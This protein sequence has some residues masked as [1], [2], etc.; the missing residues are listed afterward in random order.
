MFRATLSTLFLFLIFA[1]GCARKDQAGN[2]TDEKS[3]IVAALNKGD[4]NGA[5]ARIDSALATHPDD[6][7]LQYF[8]AQALS[9]KS[10]IDVYSLF[11]V[12]KIKLFEVAMTEWQSYQKYKALSESTAGSDMSQASR[13]AALSGADEMQK[14]LKALKDTDIT[15]EIDSS[16]NYAQGSCYQYTQL[17]SP[18]L[19]N[20]EIKGVFYG[21][22]DLVYEYAEIPAG[23]ECTD[24][25]K[26]GFEAKKTEIVTR[27][28]WNAH[29]QIERRRHEIIDSRV[30]SA[31]VQG[32]Y[33][34]FDAVPILKDLPRYKHEN[35]ATTS[36]AIDILEG[37]RRRED[38]N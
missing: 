21:D 14:K 15:F 9:S 8:K 30:A 7:E 20:M 19:R 11:P 28:R 10:E 2:Q 27:I 22:D 35:L 31:Y 38:K 24:K 13:E 4:V 32:I 29:N 1:A 23:K 17:I 18:V 34:L 25:D 37:I 3:E 5:L 26:A 6:V 36:R 33:V 12:L 16:W